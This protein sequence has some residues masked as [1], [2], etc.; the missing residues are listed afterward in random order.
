MSFDTQRMNPNQSGSADGEGDDDEGESSVDPPMAIVVMGVSGSGKTV[1]ARELST[2]LDWP[3]AEGDD[4]H[5]TDNIRK[6][7]SGV[8]LVDADRWGW[9]RSIA[10]WMD[11]SAARGES[12]VVSCSAL[13][14]S[15]RDVLRRSGTVFV[16]LNGSR[17][18]LRNRLAGRTGHFMKVDM[19]DSQLTDF[20][21]PQ[22]DERHVDIDVGRG[23]DPEEEA[24]TVLTILGL[25]PAA[26]LDSGMVGAGRG[27]RGHRP[28]R[29]PAGK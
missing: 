21:P 1:L 23:M 3:Y 4:F 22:D 14:K 28:S 27:D 16:C 5:P 11:A 26:D 15:Y 8:P 17:D 7:A 13:K 6:M 29:V 25:A 12:V 20:E 9:L 24:M 2:I 18:A 10:E 19:L